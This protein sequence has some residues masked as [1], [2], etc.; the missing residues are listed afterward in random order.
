MIRRLFLLLLVLVGCGIKSP[1]PRIDFLEGT[2]A[3]RAVFLQAAKDIGIDRRVVV[4]RPDKLAHAPKAVAEAC[5]GCDP[6]QIWV[7]PDRFSSDLKYTV[8]MHEYGH[9]VGLEHS[10]NMF[11]VMYHLANPWSQYTNE[12]KQRYYDAVK[13]ARG[14]K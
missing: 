13:A 1:E 7:V 12:A 8:F 10:D 9:C 5:V 4:Y 3:Y 6:C 2:E 11:D 14:G